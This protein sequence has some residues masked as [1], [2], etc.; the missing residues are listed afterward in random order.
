MQQRKAVITAPDEDLRRPIL[1]NIYK[2]LLLYVVLLYEFDDLD[3][4]I[5]QKQ[6]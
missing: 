4:G 5:S 2:R 6:T 1:K 3:Q